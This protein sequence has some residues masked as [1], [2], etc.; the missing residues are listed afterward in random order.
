MAQSTGSARLAIVAG[1]TMIGIYAVQFVAARFSL[2]EHLTVTDMVVLRFA[3]AGAAFLPLVWRSGF[4]RI[5]ASGWRRALALAALA[6]L[7]Y[8]LIINW[9]LT[10]APAVHGAALCPASIVV[11]SFLLSIFQERASH[12]R[13][14]G[15][16]TIIVGLLLFIAPARGSNEVL[17]GDLLFVGSGLM[18]S[19]YATLVRQW[20]IDPFTATA[21]VVLLSC[22]PLPFLALF[23]P[24]GLHAAA[25][26]EIVGQVIIQGLLAG[27]AAMFLYTYI[28]G[29][30][31]SQAAS[32][33]M[34]GVPIAT[35]VVG[36][37]VLGE[38][39]TPI[40]F[41]AVA[42][43]AAGMGFSAMARRAARAV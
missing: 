39:P 24:S 35:V 23:A 6:G 38:T 19:A 29:Q 16:A 22:L 13:T 25:S 15:V 10:Y 30:L 40:Q 21:A 27:A 14:I 17:L 11:F 31:G 18:F 20:R 5:R 3:G 32:L 8:P 34:P 42:I 41:A 12:Q 26:A 43:M 36:M 33:F 7:P 37:V 28:V 9:G 1:L 4:A 2:R